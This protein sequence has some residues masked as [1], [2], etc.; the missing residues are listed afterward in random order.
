MKVRAKQL[1]MTAAAGAVLGTASQA[2]AT[3]FLGWADQFLGA[4]VH[5]NFWDPPAGEVA[6]LHKWRHAYT[7]EPATWDYVGAQGAN[8]TGRANARE[9]IMY[10][11]RDNSSACLAGTA[12]LARYRVSPRPSPGTTCNVSSTFVTSTSQTYDTCGFLP[13]DHLF[14]NSTAPTLNFSAE[15]AG[16]GTTVGYRSIAT[17]STSDGQNSSQVGCYSIYWQ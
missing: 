13:G 5:V 7:W 16:P 12:S 2:T 9:F 1:L 15:T 4:E 8:A 14:Q 10:R 17:I 6:V 11:F 3:D